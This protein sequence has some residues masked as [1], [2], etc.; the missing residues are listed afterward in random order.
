MKMVLIISS[1]R[2]GGAERVLSILANHWQAS[3][4]DIHLITIDSKDSD[5]YMVNQG[6]RRYSL[7]MATAS[8]EVFSGTLANIKRIS[9]IRQ[10]CK[11]IRPEIVLSFIDSTNILSSIALMGTSIP[12]VVSER[13]D[14]FRYSIGM[15]RTFM[16]PWLYRNFASAL[17]VQTESVKNKCKKNWRMQQ[18]LVIEN[19][20]SLPDV[21]EICARSRVVL[22]VGRL[23]TQKGHDILIRAFQKISS[24]FPEWKLLIVGEGGQRKFL[25][26]II[27]RLDMREKILMPGLSDDIF[28]H[29]KKASIF[30][31]PSRFEGFPNAL[32]EAL[33]MGCACIATDCES[34][35]REILED[36][37][38]GILTP[39]DD[40][41]AMADALCKLMQDSELRRQYSSHSDYVRAHYK[42]ESI[43]QQWLDL[44][45]QVKK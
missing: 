36:G 23:S 19:P 21:S 4:H 5:F 2:S 43:S 13:I 33:A 39:V 38:L 6:V 12:L 40:V 3:R 25:E 15:V 7:D 45:S 10:L 24:E 30:C 11:T 9:K 29:Y 26:E 27:S 34:G 8:V 41:D 22:S 1:L 20:L 42:L 16:R 14:P 28:E 35:P 44:F 32:L 37:K 31:M 18:A 17:V